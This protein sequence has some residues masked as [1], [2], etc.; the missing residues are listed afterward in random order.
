MAVPSVGKSK[1]HFMSFFFFFI[2]QVWPLNDKVVCTSV[3]RDPN[4]AWITPSDL[5]KDDKN[6][7]I[8]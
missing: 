2:F 5:V 4:P 8:V 6:C 1:L 7:D 3:H